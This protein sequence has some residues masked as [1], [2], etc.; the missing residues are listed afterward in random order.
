MKREPVAAY[1]ARGDV[2]PRSRNIKPGF[3]VNDELTELPPLARLLFAGLWCVADRA[4]RLLDRPKRIKLEVLPADDCDVDSMLWQLQAHGFIVRY[5]ADG[6]NLIEICNWA[7]HQRPH[8]T[9]QLPTCPAAT[10]HR[11]RAKP[12]PE[13][14][15]P[16]IT[17]IAPLDDG[18]NP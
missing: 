3:F 2:M 9:V 8:H 5:E 14:E 7:K 15:L 13:N 10:V 1:A 17:A 18:K 12:L 11:A 6:A 16:D 4:G